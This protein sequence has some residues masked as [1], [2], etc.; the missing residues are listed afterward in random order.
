MEITER[1]TRVNCPGWRGES[2][3]CPGGDPRIVPPVR[4]RPAAPL[5]ALATCLA[6]AGLAGSAR[7]AAGEDE[8]QVSARL[9][10]GDVDIDGRAPFGVLAGADL[11]YG[12]TDAWAARLSLGT[13]FHNVNADMKNRLPG[14][15]VRA[16]TA[17]VG[18]TYTFD[19][20]RLVPYIQTGIGVINFGGAVTRPGTQL[21]AELGLGADYLITR[22]WALGSVLQ[23]QF[24]PAN[25]FGSAMEFGGTSFY[26]ALAARVSW[27]F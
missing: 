22:R 18:V 27:L 2:P 10:L 26:F 3:P 5:V 4:R 23:Y 16:T 13:G 15:R 20:L 8:W 9:G 14:G 21:D 1:S 17:L 25:L 11:E 19:V 6:L 7:A 12:F 24:T